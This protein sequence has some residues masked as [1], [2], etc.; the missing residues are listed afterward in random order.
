MH[1]DNPRLFFVA[2]PYPLSFLSPTPRSLPSLAEKIRTEKELGEIEEK[3]RM[4]S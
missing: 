4:R 3:D 2:S 1:G